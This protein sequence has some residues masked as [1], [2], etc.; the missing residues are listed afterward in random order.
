MADEQWIPMADYAG[1][2]HVVGAGMC[3]I[4]PKNGNQYGWDCVQYDGPRQ[5]LHIYR[6]VA[7]TF[8]WERVATFEGTKDAERGFERGQCFIGQGGALVVGTTMIPKG[9]PYVTETGF[10]GVRCRIP[11]ID[12]PWSWPDVAAIMLRLAA[13]E[14]RLED[15]RGGGLDAADREALDRLRDDAQII[16]TPPA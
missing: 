12:E 13:V 10:Q 1:A 5:N 16:A 4:H 14:A 2:H 15:L 11:N 7:K 3:F 9:V 8:V 6:L